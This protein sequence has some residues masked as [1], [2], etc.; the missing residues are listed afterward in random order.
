MSWQA[1]IQQGW[2]GT[3]C[4]FTGNLLQGERMLCMRDMAEICVA[5]VLGNNSGKTR[6][7]GFALGSD[8]SVYICTFGTT[9][10]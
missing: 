10:Q 2:H 7:A 4:R 3:R 9:V 1:A 5:A 8:Q 6:Q